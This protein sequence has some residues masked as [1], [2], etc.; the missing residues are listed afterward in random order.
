MHKTLT[1]LCTVALTTASQA[2]NLVWS[3][4]PFTDST[5]L[6]TQGTTVYA[7]NMGTGGNLTVNGIDFTAQNAATVGTV[8]GLRWGSTDSATNNASG[9][10]GG[11]LGVAGMSA[12]DEVAFLNTIIYGGS[13]AGF[14]FKNLTV[15]ETYTAQFIV[16]DNRGGFVNRNMHFSENGGVWGGGGS[17]LVD[18]TSNSANPG[19]NNWARIVSTTFV[20][21]NA[22][23][24]KP[25]DTVSREMDQPRL[26]RCSFVLSPSPHQPFLRLSVVLPSSAA[27]ARD[28]SS[29]LFFKSLL[30]FPGQQVFLCPS[31]Q[32]KISIHSP[33]SRS[34][35]SRYF[36]MASRWRLITLR[37]YRA[38]ILF[39]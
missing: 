21:D 13:G 10:Y 24:R 31:A 39:T 7:H 4:D 33:G 36:P 37:L 20:A 34:S 5:Q 1:F 25:S 18:Y 16:V 6:N 8:N 17:V 30:S 26:R 35:G 22:T 15:G 38:N 9:L 29:K 28:Q 27:G 23:Q 2:V 32:G 11:A 19:P 12:G 3:D 14:Q